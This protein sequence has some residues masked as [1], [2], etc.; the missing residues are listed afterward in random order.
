[1]FYVNAYEGILFCALKNSNGT[2]SK[3]TDGQKY[4]ACVEREEELGCGFVCCGAAVLQWIFKE[5]IRLNVSFARNL[6]CVSGNPV[7]AFL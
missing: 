5:L 4:C 6:R 7:D 1:M 3:R 2:E